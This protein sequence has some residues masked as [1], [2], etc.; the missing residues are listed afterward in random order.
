MK[1]TKRE[2]WLVDTAL[3]SGYAEGFYEWIADN[4]PPAEEKVCEWTYSNNDGYT[5]SHGESRGWIMGSC[6]FC[7]DCGG[8]ITEGGSE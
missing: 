1:L 4:A 7:N 6:K 8:R 5:D 2:K 3:Q